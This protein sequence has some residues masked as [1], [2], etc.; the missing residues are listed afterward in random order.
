MRYSVE[1]MAEV[2]WKHNL[3]LQA[4]DKDPFPDEPW[5]A[6]PEWRRKILTGIVEGV[7]SGNLRGPEDTHFYWTVNMK[8]HGWKFG[9]EKDLIRE[10]HPSLRP[11]DRLESWQRLAQEANFKTIRDMAAVP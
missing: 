8:A 11:W 3:A 5:I 1:D 10:L 7:L 9:P 4:V 2:C 6:A